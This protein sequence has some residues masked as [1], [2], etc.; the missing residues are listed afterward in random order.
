MIYFYYR[1]KG[2]RF[3]YNDFYDTNL[4]STSSRVDAT[5][6]VV[7]AVL[8]IIGGIVAYFLFISKKKDNFSGFL[9]WLHDFLNFKVYFIDMFLKT[10]YVICTIYITLGS[11]SLIGSSVAAFFLMLIMGNVMLRVGYEF[12]LMFLTLVNNTTDINSK[13]TQSNNAGSKE[14]V[15]N[16]KNEKTKNENKNVD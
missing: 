16:P 2:E 1:K 12:I 4:I 5:W 7:S 10:L 13:L 3:M 9:A 14:N 11:F 6:L 8:A 15:K